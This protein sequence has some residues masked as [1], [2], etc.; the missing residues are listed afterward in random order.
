[1]K[2]KPNDK[3]NNYDVTI[4]LGIMRDWQSEKALR[5]ALPEL[6]RYRAKSEP[7]LLRKQA[8]IIR[9]GRAK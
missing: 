5:E 3:L 9:V 7:A 4:N 1:M 6:V 2:Q 8:R